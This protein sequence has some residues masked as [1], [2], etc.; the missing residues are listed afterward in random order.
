MIRMIRTCCLAFSMYSRIP[1]PQ[2]EYKEE[3]VKYVFL[4]FPLIGVVIGALEY[5]GLYLC[6]ALGV[7]A[8]F[9]SAVAVSIPFFVTGGFHMDGYMDTTDALSSY[10]DREK[11]LKI[12][13]DSH[14]GAFAV[15]WCGVYILLNFGVY[16]EFYNYKMI[17]KAVVFVPCVYIIS[18]ITSGLA[19]LTFNSANISTAGTTQAGSSLAE[20]KKASSRKIVV[21]VLAIYLILVFGILF[22]INIFLAFAML[23]ALGVCYLYYY[24]MSKRNFGGITGDLAGWYLQVCE[25]LLLIVIVLL[26]RWN[27]VAI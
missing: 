23:L 4:F 15:I 16:A 5:G 24:T 25:L 7:G 18:R 8:V 14:V 12:L 22:C 6:R 2:L 19:A 26:L 27:G 11:R 3:D 17:G 21:S 1:M 10:G 9:Y 20:V 13:K